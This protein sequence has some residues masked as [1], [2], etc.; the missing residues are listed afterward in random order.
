MND[1]H[2]SDAGTGTVRVPAGP[3]A[4][5]ASS[6]RVAA[7]APLDAT[8]A[9]FILARFRSSQ[10]LDDALHRLEAAGFGREDL[11]LPEMD[12]APVL[13]TPETASRPADID[14]D[15]QQSR[16]FHSAVG[17]SF[18][19]MMAATAVAATGGVAAAVAGA[20]LG[21]GAAVAGIA[22]L[23]SRALSH[24]EQQDRDRKASEGRLFLAVR[25]VSDQRRDNAV[26]VLR[27]AGAEVL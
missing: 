5:A 25:T 27:E 23:T 3:A 7:T 2:L 24:S 18:A 8:E 14:T 1:R 26:A 10:A 21:V 16:I 17:G 4:P 15:A 9:D 19:A 20:A 12:V 22:H 13:R 11:G 6:D